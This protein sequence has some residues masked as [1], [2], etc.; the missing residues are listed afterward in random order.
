V[1]TSRLYGKTRERAR[2]RLDLLPYVRSFVRLFISPNDAG[3]YPRRQKNG[4]RL[5]FTLTHT[6]EDY[7]VPESYYSYYLRYIPSRYL[8]Y[9]LTTYS[10]RIGTAFNSFLFVR[11]GGALR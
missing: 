2:P 5:T 4:R 3:L 10:V 6:S 8:Q 11:V 9:S 7:N 1:L